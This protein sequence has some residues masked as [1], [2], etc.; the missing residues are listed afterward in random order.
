MKVII[1]ETSEKQRG[2]ISKLTKRHFCLVKKGVN[3]R[4]KYGLNKE[5]N[6]MIKMHQ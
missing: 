4:T 3:L 2:Q 1:L 5:R 6:H